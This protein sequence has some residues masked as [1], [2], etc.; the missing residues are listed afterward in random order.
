MANWSATC[1]HL[2]LAEISSAMP[3][4]DVLETVWEE[5]FNESVVPRIQFHPWLATFIYMFFCV[6]SRYEYMLTFF[7]CVMDRRRHPG[8]SMNSSSSSV[9]ARSE[10]AG[11]IH[12]RLR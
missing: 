3:S 12:A 8:S 4:D 5:F 7:S 11:Q 9:R 2:K 6:V 10:D 1:L